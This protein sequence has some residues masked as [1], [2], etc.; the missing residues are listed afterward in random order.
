MEKATQHRGSGAYK[1]ALG[2]RSWNSHGRTHGADFRASCVPQQTG[3]QGP[4]HLG[5]PH[6]PYRNDSSG[7]AGSCSSMSDPASGQELVRALDKGYEKKRREAQAKA[8]KTGQHG[9]CHI[10]RPSHFPQLC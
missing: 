8:G 3:L 9:R 6:C 5:P 4:R 10:K 7:E 2:R 1:A